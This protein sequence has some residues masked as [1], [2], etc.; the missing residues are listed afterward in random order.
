MIRKPA[1]LA[2]PGLSRR[3]VVLAGS[4]ACLAAW[5]G[6][7]FGQAVPTN[8]AL[9]DP[10]TKV[11]F[12]G[13]S[14]AD[15]LW[16]SFVRSFTREKCLREHMDGGR[17]AKNGTGL[18]RTDGHDWPV[19]ARKIAETYGPA[20]VVAS[21]GL[22][23]R[24][25]VVD[26]TRARA[27]YGT[28]AWDAA[29]KARVVLF[30]QA[31]ASLGAGVLL[32]GLPA[33]RDAVQK[34]DAEAKNKL[35]SEAVGSMGEGRISY[36]EP[37]QTPNAAPGTFASAVPGEGGRG[38]VQVRAPDGIHFTPAGYDMVWAYLFPKLVANLKQTGHEAGL[39]CAGP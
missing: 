28:P 18:T 27:T 33:M 31:A 29:Y 7:V 2:T 11:A 3:E 4:A 26:G 16:G 14:M 24:Q 36:V 32:I 1:I 12:I 23:D 21:I 8:A 22:N 17:Y 19:Q 35:F 38:L 9:P 5:A 6:P 20:A 15:G 39:D 25:D 34:A 10:K 13:D 30:C 37:W